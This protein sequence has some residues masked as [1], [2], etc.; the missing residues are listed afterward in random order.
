MQ[1]SQPTI[2]K[3]NSLLSAATL[4]RQSFNK[5][6]H[7]ILELI[8]YVQKPLIKVHSDVHVSYGAR[9]LM[10][11]LGLPLLANFVYASSECSGETACLSL[12]C[13]PM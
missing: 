4:E 11:H 2:Q 1:I 5:Q 12:R 3:T 10:F 6:M 13:L 9:C 7:E 8:T